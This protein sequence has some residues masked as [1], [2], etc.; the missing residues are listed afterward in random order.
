[1]K[2]TKIDLV[3]ATSVVLL[4]MFGLIMVFS[5]SSMLANSVHGDLTH[6]LRKQVLWAAITIALIISFSK[7]DYTILKK[8][9]NP[10]LLVLVSIVLL[11]GLFFFGASSFLAVRR[12]RILL[13]AL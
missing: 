11:L 12:T 6:F 2:N 7:I 9:G 4:I 10:V 1:M 5:A 3:I 8:N 13:R